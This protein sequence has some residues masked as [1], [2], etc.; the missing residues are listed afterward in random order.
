MLYTGKGDNG[1]T[2]LYGCD[3]RLSKSSAIAEALGTVD[4]INSFLGLVKATA[5]R[6]GYSL[7]GKTFHDIAHEIQ[8][9]LFIVQAE[10]A[11]ADKRMD[12]AHVTKLE[13]WIAVAEGELPPIKT[14]FVPGQTEL[15]A[16]F[17]VARTVARRAERRV[18]GALELHAGEE[19]T[20][21]LGEE[22]KPPLLAYL[23]R[24]SSVLYALAR[25]SV[26]KS[27]LKEE[28]PHY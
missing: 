24:L 25:L 7:A 27:G 12:E 6:D 15:G 23:N 13:K 16:L 28:A 2:S 18:I 4:E 9:D 10:L 3:Q 8:H 1:M 19:G 11:G 17:D 5:K 22:E 21:V 26:H 20:P 14:F